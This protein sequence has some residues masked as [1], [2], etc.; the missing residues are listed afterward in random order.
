MPE[1]RRPRGDT[2]RPRSGAAAGRSNPRLR[3]GVVA[4]RRCPC[5]KPE[6]RGGGPE[7]IPHAP[8]PEAKG[9]DGE[10]QPHD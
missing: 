7:E 3:S 4:G 5:P 9:G 8:K 10:E 2:P 6:A 1:G